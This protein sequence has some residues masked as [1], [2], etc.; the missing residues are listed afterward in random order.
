MIIFH[1]S[2]PFLF[3]TIFTTF[4]GLSLSYDT[5]TKY[6]IL[7]PNLDKLPTQDKAIE[8]FQ[9]W[10]KDY[11]RVYKDLQEMSKKFDIFLSNLKYITENNA[12]RKSPHG[13]LLGLTNFSDWSSQEFKER[14]LH[15]IDMSMNIDTIKVNDVHGLSS[16]DAPSSLDWRSKGAVTTVKNQHGCG[17]LIVFAYIYIILRCCFYGRCSL[18]IIWLS[19]SWCFSL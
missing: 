12:K 14:Y 17:K 13:F 10:M 19:D 5:P 4:L 1:T 11:G 16:C 9:Q 3:F 2:K 18:I 8:L 7:G 6:S 15:D